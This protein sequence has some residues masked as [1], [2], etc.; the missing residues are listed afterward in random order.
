LKHKEIRDRFE[1]INVW[2]RGGQRAPHKPLLALYAIGRL[3]R[4]EPRMIAFRDV[5]K[6]LG[7]LL[8]DFGPCRKSVHPE[9]PFWRLKNDGLWELTNTESVCPR[10]GN[11]D[12]RKKD[13]LENNV[14]GGFPLSIQGTLAKDRKLLSDIVE[15]L[16]DRNFP[17]TLHGDIL[18]AVGIDLSESTDTVKHVR[19]PGFRRRILR[20]YEYRCAVCGFQVRLGDRLVALEAGHIKWHQ[21]G[22]PD[23]EQNGLALCSMHHKLFDAGVFTIS[24]SMR[25]VVSE[26]AHGSQGFQDWVM[27]FHGKNIKRP[28]RTYFF[29]NSTFVNWHVREVFQGPCREVRSLPNA[30]K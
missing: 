13:L 19:D 27:A 20:A 16:L 17:D 9:Y 23:I 18:D 14:A 12:A 5:N 22:G 2:K 8:K 24:N 30:E 21:A 11:T 28:L 4:G 6:H 26:E 7:I 3:Q 29:P 1:A 10:K 25:V 15:I